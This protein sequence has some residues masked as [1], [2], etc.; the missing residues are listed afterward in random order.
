[1][2]SYLTNNPRNPLLGIDPQSSS[3]NVGVST[4]GGTPR[5]E[6]RRIGRMRLTWEEW[7]SLWAEEGEYHRGRV[8][9]QGCN[10][11]NADE[12]IYFDDTMVAS[13]LEAFGDGP[14]KGFSVDC[15]TPGQQLKVFGRRK[16]SSSSSP[17]L[18]LPSSSGISI[19]YTPYQVIFLFNLM[20]LNFMY[21]V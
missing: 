21:N 11:L 14:L 3:L 17:S 10:F 8:K 9:V 13:S 6:L 18:P 4:S 12:L 7:V 16:L 15:F 2:Q 5:V 20:L 19:T 1:M